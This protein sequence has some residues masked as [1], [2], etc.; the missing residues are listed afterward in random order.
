MHIILTAWCFFETWTVVAPACRASCACSRWRKR[1]RNLSC[2]GCP[3]PSR[4]LHRSLCFLKNNLINLI[5]PTCKVYLKLVSAIVIWRAS[6]NK[7][8]W[9]N[10]NLL[11]NFWEQEELR[12]LAHTCTVEGKFESFH[13]WNYIIALVCSK[14]VHRALKKRWTSHFI[15]HHSCVKRC[16]PLCRV[17]IASAC[18]RT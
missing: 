18:R 7:S 14:K 6:I 8:I 16:R 3:R 4:N 17:G 5:W 2:P 12:I 10:Y 13:D 9:F 15:C 11:V 1:D